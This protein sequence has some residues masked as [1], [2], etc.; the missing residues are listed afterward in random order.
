MLMNLS[1]RPLF[2][3]LLSGLGSGGRKICYNQPCVLA[4]IFR[5][6]LNN[7]AAFEHERLRG[8]FVGANTT[9]NTEVRINYRHLACFILEL[10]YATL[11]FCWHLANSVLGSWGV[12]EM[13]R[14][15]GATLDAK[16]IANTG[17]GIIVHSVV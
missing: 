13:Y 1:A 10:H 4:C 7:L 17:L 14:S 5:R 15:H 3:S 2:V 16:P 6:I 9:A 12:F 8:A 11:I